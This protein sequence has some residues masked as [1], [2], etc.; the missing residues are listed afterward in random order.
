ML[1]LVLTFG[2][3]G[4][5][6]IPFSFTYIPI[7]SVFGPELGKLFLYLLALPIST[8]PILIA[9]LL[10]IDIIGSKKRIIATILSL[11]LISILVVFAFSML[12]FPQVSN[13]AKIID[14]FV[15]KNSN[16]SLDETAKNIA[17][18]LSQNFNN[19]YNGIE[20]LYEIDRYFY[21]TLLDP[22]LIEMFNVT[23]A[24]IIL[25]QRW[26]S[27]GQEADLVE[28]ILF[29]SGYETRTAHFIGIDHGWAEA[30]LN[31]T[32]WI[33]NPGYIGNITEIS[34]LRST[35]SAFE[36]ATDIEIMYRN[37][38]NFFNKEAYGY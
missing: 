15:S 32:W 30:H 27:C 14:E 25:Y 2:Y 38:T 23:R 1:F 26:G 29:R 34:K 19:S 35:K 20:D 13:K 6:A 3:M 8:I 11:V 21:G 22:V 18:F 33:I 17:V 7:G 31:G 24:E 37:G 5:S 12:F 36:Q 4:F 28:E 9:R 16:N 10:N